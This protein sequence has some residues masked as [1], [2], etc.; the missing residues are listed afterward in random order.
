MCWWRLDRGVHPHS[1]Q[2][3]RDQYRSEQPPWLGF[4][5]WEQLIPLRIAPVNGRESDRESRDR[6]EESIIRMH[7]TIL[8]KIAY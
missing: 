5:F 6:G 1:E 4:I 3:S 7:G 2:C 8:T